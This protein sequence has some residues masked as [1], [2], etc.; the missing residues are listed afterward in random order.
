MKPLKTIT[1]VL[2]LFVSLPMFAQRGSVGGSSGGSSGSNPSGG[3]SGGGNT[4]ASARACATLKD[5]LAVQICNQLVAIGKD[6][7]TKEN[8]CSEFMSKVGT[9]CPQVGCQLCRQGQSLYDFFVGNIYSNLKSLGKQL[10]AG[11]NLTPAEQSTQYAVIMAA[12]DMWARTEMVDGILYPGGYCIECGGTGSGGLRQNWQ[13][14]VFSINTC[15]PPASCPDDNQCPDIPRCKSEPSMPCVFIALDRPDPTSH[16]ERC[17]QRAPG[18]V[19]FKYETEQPKCK[20]SRGEHW[21]AR[22]DWVRCP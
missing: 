9:S 10:L 11:T 5:S 12:I 21:K 17:R 7:V 19:G 22:V 14:N 8:K 1:F 6:R 15:G 4:S 20:D 2:M 13:Y 16:Q 3:G 18:V